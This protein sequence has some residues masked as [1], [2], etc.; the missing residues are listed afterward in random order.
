MAGRTGRAARNDEVILAAA[1][2]VFLADP[3]APVAAVAARAGVGISALY[4]RYPAK[5][6][7]L[8]TLCA[9]GLARFV[10]EAERAAAVPGPWAAFESFLRAVVD[11]DVHSLTMRLAGTFPPDERL[12][13]QA[14]QATALAEG[15]FRRARPFLRAGAV[16]ADVTMILE[17]CAAARVPDAE[18]TRILRGR[19]LTM[20]LDGLRAG[21]PLPGPAPA[22]AELSGRWLQPTKTQKR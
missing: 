14:R 16:A 22:T 21:G 19:Y 13:A 5:E 7:L 20:L 11:A 3:R 8:R 6:D 10:A 4:R 2:A 18:R 9:Q 15:L 1:R 17:L 12:R